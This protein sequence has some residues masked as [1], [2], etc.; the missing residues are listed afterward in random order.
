M[1]NQSKQGEI[2]PHKNKSK[3]ECVAE[4][5]RLNSVISNL[6]QQL[7]NSVL[8]GGEINPSDIF[9]K[10]FVCYEPVEVK[11]IRVIL[12]ETPSEFAKRFA[13]SESAVK[14]WETPRGLAKHAECLGAAGK[15]MY[16]AA[17]VANERGSG[18]SIRLSMRG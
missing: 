14:S 6:T 8:K 1:N 4:I 17:V 3:E 7:D 2:D 15:L 12:K 13:V 18:N 11:L 5:K 16:W 10:P 9:K